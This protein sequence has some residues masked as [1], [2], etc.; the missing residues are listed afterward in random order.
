MKAT[1]KIIAAMDRSLPNYDD[2]VLKVIE[3][4]TEINPVIDNFHF[5]VPGDDRIFWILPGSKSNL[6]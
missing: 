5:M 4:G 6:W 2:S 3:A 1:T